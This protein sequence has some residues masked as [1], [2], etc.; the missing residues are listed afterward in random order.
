MSTST[1]NK[2]KFGLKNTH[3]ARLTENSDGT[4]SFGTPRAFP[5]AIS[6]SLEAQGDLEPF[7]AD[8][9][10]Y[11]RSTS[12]N[13]YSGDLETALIP[14]WFREEYL[15]EILD[16]NN[17]LI[18]SANI[19]DPVYFALMCEFS[20]DKHKIRHVLYKCSASRPSV[21]SQTKENSNTPVTDTLP[22][23]VDPLSNGM[24]KGKSTAD[25]TSAVY[26]SWY[27]AVYMSNLTEE[28][29]NG[30][31]GTATL[32]GLT[33]SGIS[34]SPSFDAAKTSYTGTTSSDSAAITASAATGVGVAII[35]NGNSISSGDDATW[36]TG[37]NTVKITASKDGSASTTYM[38][39]ITKN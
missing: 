29:L 6:L 33:I 15:G 24:V 1:N 3:V 9:G 32:T 19:T 38:V 13:G 31:S 22:I 37:E 11:F 39:K 35:V 34:L 21:A 27:N 36:V 12:N 26:T 16:E 23:T 14:D 18:E 30:G 2:V 20:G 4:F 8:D 25:T 5:G 17:V 28:Q 10:V 7:Y